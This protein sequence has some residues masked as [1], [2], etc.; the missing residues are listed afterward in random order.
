MASCLCLSSLS[1]FPAD[2]IAGSKV[3]ASRTGLTNGQSHNTI[4]P[5]VHHAEV[6]ELADA[7]ASGA[8]EPCAHA[9]SNLAFGKGLPIA[10]SGA[11]FLW[12]IPVECQ[13]YASAFAVGGPAAA[14]I[15][16]HPATSQDGGSQRRPALSA[17]RRIEVFRRPCQP[18]QLS[19]ESI[20]GQNHY[21]RP[22]G[23]YGNQ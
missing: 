5:S 10:G 15:R 7:L 22:G 2:S 1:L 16:A 17:D 18:D 9:S 20:D 3:A 4:S 21:R 13:S 11:L 23:G 8:S 6:A 12:A 19:K 14:Q